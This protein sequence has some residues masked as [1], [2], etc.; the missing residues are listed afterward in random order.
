MSS[1]IL[2]VLM[3]WNAVTECYDYV[4]EPWSNYG[5]EAQ[6]RRGDKSWQTL[7]GA[8]VINTPAGNI[9]AITV[10]AA[11]NELD[12]EKQ[13]IAGMNAAVLASFQAVVVQTILTFDGD[14]LTY[15][16]EVLT[17]G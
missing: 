11:I 7:N 12:A 14:I 8:A 2:G 4:A 1:V 15:N 17:Y 16:G 13:S 9:E 3:K 6:Y 5:N 10:Q